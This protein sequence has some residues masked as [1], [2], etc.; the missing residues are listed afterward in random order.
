MS[1]A[2]GARQRWCPDLRVDRGHRVH[3]GGRPGHR[4]RHRPRHHRVRPGR[5]RRRPL[6]PRAGREGRRA[7]S[8]CRP[9]STTT[10][11]PSRWRAS[12][13]DVPIVEDPERYGYYRE[14]GGGLLVGLF[15]P[16]AA[17]WSLDAIPQRLRVLRRCRPTGT[18]WRRSCRTPA[19]ASR[20]SRT[21]VSRRSF[22]GPESFTPDLGPMIG[23][24]PELD[25][26]FVACGMNSVG[27]LSGGGLGKIMAEWMVEGLPPVDVSHMHVDRAQPFEVTRRFR[28]ERAVE[29]LACLLNDGGWP[30]Y[31]A[32]DRRGVR[33]SI[34]HDRLAADGACFMP[35]GDGSTSSS[36]ASLAARQ[37]TRGSTAAAR[38]SSAR[39]TSTSR[40]AR[41][42]QRSTSR[43]CPS[44]SCRAP[45]PSASS[46]R[47]APATST[48]PVGR[49]VYTQWLDSRGRINADLTVTRSPR[50]SSSS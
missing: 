41:Q 16:V 44:S 38:R 37:R 15:E 21:P 2:K 40:P 24:S 20:P 36:S 29:S 33:R 50:T 28:S 6:G 46:T 48:V 4:G 9:P 12:T 7:S 19:S 27:I 47:S 31:A 10:C 8:R 35:S 17:A 11:S 30:N 3:P 32:A 13:R 34:L 26:F 42:S 1:L 43:R 39:A 25:G 5:P 22:C 23:E 18:G 45:T 14:E 49:I